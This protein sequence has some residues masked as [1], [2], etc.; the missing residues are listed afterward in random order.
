MLD[1]PIPRVLEPAGWFENK[2]EIERR[3]TILEARLWAWNYWNWRKSD[4]VNDEEVQRFVDELENPMLRPLKEAL[5]LFADLTKNSNLPL[6]ALLKEREDLRASFRHYMLTGELATPF[7]SEFEINHLFLDEISD[8][9]SNAG[10]YFDFTT[11]THVTVVSKKRFMKCKRREFEL[12]NARG[13]IQNLDEFGRD[14]VRRMR[15]SEINFVTIDDCLD[16]QK[17]IPFQSGKI[18]YECDDSATATNHFIMNVM[19][20]KWKGIKVRYLF[21]FWWG[22]GHA[23]SVASYGGSLYIVDGSTGVILGPFK[24][25]EEVEIAA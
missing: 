1:R 5:E 14:L 17:I 19:G 7:D 12:M 24:T 4:L 22:N 21:V 2:I 16:T 23:M 11:F 3:L 13:N 6:D 10:Y 15:E 18:G 20:P 8:R 25:E 9:F